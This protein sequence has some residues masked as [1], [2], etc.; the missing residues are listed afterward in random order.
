MNDRLITVFGASGFIGRYVVRAL[1]KRGLRVLAAVR[2]P[3]AAHFLRP[4]GDVGQIQI[5]QSNV[6]VAPT[7]AK[8]VEGAWG[9]VNL[10]GVL[11]QSGAQRFHSLHIDAAGAIAA[12]ATKAGAQSLLHVSAIGADS[13]SPSLYARTKALGEAA[14][15]AAFPKAIVARPSI[16][17]GPEDE[18]FNKFAEMARLSP[19]LPLFGGGKTRFQPIYAGDLGEALARALLDPASAAKTYELGGPRVYTFRELMEEICRATGRKR[20]LLPL[21]YI[22]AQ[23]VALGFVFMPDFVMEPLITFDQVKLLKIDN[24][25]HEGMAGVRD[26]GLAPRALETELPAYLWRF[27]KTG[28]F[29]LTGAA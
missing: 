10:V 11:R 19:V 13:A 5:V 1:A 27:R 24:V 29:E 23:A 26:L 16:V 12:A 7:I 21:P 2:N 6:R 9:V 20:V 17:F 8:A 18:F 22:A 3:A 25:V 14:V 28:Q 4:L 15:R